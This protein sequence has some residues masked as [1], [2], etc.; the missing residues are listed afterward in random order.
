MSV[1]M[2]LWRRLLRSVLY[3]TIGL[4]R[5]RLPGT[6]YTRFLMPLDYAPSRRLEPRWGFS[7]PPIPS[8]VD[9]CARGEVRYREIL[10][11][12]RSLAPDLAKIPVRY[13]AK[14]PTVPAWCGVPFAPIDTAL[15]Y[16]FVRL[17]QP[18]TYLEIGSGI[19]TCF[20][21][22]AITRGG[23]ETEIVS[24]D[25]EPRQ[26]INSICD[27][28]IREGL[29]TVD[30]AVFDALAPGDIVFMDG[31]HRSFMNS[32]V[33]VFMIDI[34]PRLKP[35]V[36]VH[37]HDVNLPFDYAPQM[38]PWYWNEQYLLAVYLM[39][40]RHRIEVLMPS[41]FVCR[42]PYFAGF[43]AAPPV[44]LGAANNHWSG[45]GSLWFTHTAPFD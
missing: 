2:P 37:I 36:I 35:G 13:R 3:R 23:L 33:T 19:S 15:L 25:P 30:P 39:G 9:L 20:V 29:E 40:H 44:D 6:R 34:L 11:H 43:A 24:I 4:P 22:E 28:V 5:R 31:S 7:K 16:A 17:Y 14:H 26:E 18:K 42:S 12:V 1:P 10:D 27:R 45:G 21:R 32:D 41:C 38:A 8:L